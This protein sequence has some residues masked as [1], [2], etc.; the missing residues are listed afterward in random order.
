MATRTRIEVELLGCGYFDLAAGACTRTLEVDAAS[1][2]FE[3]GDAILQAFA[4]QMDH[5]FGYYDNVDDHYDSGEKYTTFADFLDDDDPDNGGS[6]RGTP[7]SALFRPG[8]EWLFLFD[9]GDDWRFRLR[10]AET[11]RTGRAGQPARVVAAH[12][13][14]PP[15]YPDF[16]DPDADS[17]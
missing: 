4:F 3:L 16:E 9:F 11:G 5:A 15:Q 13:T 6:V 2:L 14:P 8:A 1:S 17:D 10:C 7:V 12:G